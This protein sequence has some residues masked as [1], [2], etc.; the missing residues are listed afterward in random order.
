MKRNSAFRYAILGVAGLAILFAGYSYWKHKGKN[1]QDK[2]LT[3]KVDRGNVRRTVSSTGTLQAVV[4]VQVGSQVSGRVQELHADFNSV[5]KKGQVLAL[6]DPANFQAQRE[7]AQAQLAT[8][9]ASV[10]NAEANLVNRRAELS[11]AKANVEFSRVTLKEAERQL[12]RTQGLFQDGLIAQRDLE[13]AQATFEQGGAKL[14]QAEAQVN[15]TEAGIRSALSQQDQAAANVKQA[16]AELTMADVNLRYTSIV[17]PIDGVVIERSVDIGQTVAAS[18]QAPLLFLIA[19]D[20]T[21]MQVIAQIDEADIGAL[22]EKAKVDFSVDAFPGQ[23][24]RGE[25]AEIRLTSKLPSS[26]TSTGSSGASSGGGTASNVV[27]YNVMIDVDNPALKLRP[28]M[29]ANVNFTVASTDNVL[30][31]ANSALRYRPSDKNPEEIQKLLSSLSGEVS[32]DT[33]RPAPAGSSAASAPPQS[34]TGSSEAGG[35]GDASGRR[36]GGWQGG[37][38]SGGNR[39]GGERSW[40]GRSG[41]RSGGGAQAVI[42]PSK[43]DIYGINAGMKIRFPQAEESRPTPGMIWVLDSA[44]QP[45]PRRVRLGITNGRETALVGGDLKEGD[46][47]ITGELGD[48]DAATQQRGGTGSPFGRTPFGGGGAGGGGR[49]GGGR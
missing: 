28:G 20:L 26:S 31:V 2:Y 42:G 24:F 45:Q 13:T 43:T 15:Q 8:A 46:T 6:I 16:R 41:G 33:R 14:M 7:R 34:S 22:S 39:M 17:S 9:Q 11:S 18:F 21:K 4:T 30:K 1:P 48:E 32:A 40:Q 25:I 49:R 37:D 19:N 38:G 35:G 36:R 27:V 5:V 10:K 3:V 29:T 47:I 23:T 44:G 12:K